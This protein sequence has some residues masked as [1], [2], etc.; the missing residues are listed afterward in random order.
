ME[1]VS[2]DPIRTAHPNA[3]KAERMRSRGTR[4]FRAIIRSQIRST[5][6]HTE[7]TAG[8]EITTVSAA[9]A[10]VM[11]GTEKKASGSMHLTT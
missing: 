4:T 10:V 7:A 3:T 6:Q 8:K 1:S 5:A 11:I 2:A 9:A